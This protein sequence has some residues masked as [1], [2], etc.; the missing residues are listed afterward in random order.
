VP[1]FAKDERPSLGVLTNDWVAGQAT[2]DTTGDCSSFLGNRGDASKECSGKH[3]TLPSGRFMYGRLVGPVGQEAGG[4]V[5][6]DREADPLALGCNCSVRGLVFMTVKG[7]WFLS[8]GYGGIF[9][10]GHVPFVLSLAR[11]DH[12]SRPDPASALSAVVNADANPG[13]VHVPDSPALNEASRRFPAPQCGLL[14]TASWLLA[15]LLG[16]AASIVTASLW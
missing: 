4:L 3:V 6:A 16:V 12:T 13:L 11:G 2:T 8:Y 1:H 10:A 5:W 15:S 9:M 14:A 7:Y